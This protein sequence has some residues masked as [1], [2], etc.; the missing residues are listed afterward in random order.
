MKKVKGRDRIK[1]LGKYVGAMA[2]CEVV[3][4]GEDVCPS[5]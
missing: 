1:K 2:E 3:V 5:I 4:A